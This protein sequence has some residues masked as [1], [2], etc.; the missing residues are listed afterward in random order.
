[1]VLVG[2]GHAHVQV[3]RRFAMERLPGAQ[4]TVVVDIPVA[5]YSGMV[6]GFVAGQYRAEELEID[7]VPLARRAGARVILARAVGID[8]ANHRI[9]VE[10]RP[11]VHYDVASI[12]I[13]STVAGLELPGVR[14]H[15]FPTRPI[16][17]FVRR[18]D[19]LVEQVRRTAGAD[20]GRIVVVGGGAAGVEVA[21]ALDHR[22]KHGEQESPV[23]VSLLE[24][25]PRILPG[26]PDS[27]LRRV[28]RHAEQ[29]RIDI[30]CNQRVV[31][32]DQASVSLEGGRQLPC[33]ALVWV[34][35]AVSQPIFRESGLQTDSRGFVLVR[36]TLQVEGHDE[37]FAVGDCATLIDYPR[38]PK[39]GV[40]AV[41]QGP[42]ISDNLIAFLEGGPLRTYRPQ[43]DFLAL[44]NLADGSALGA[45]WGRAFEGPWVMRLKD[46]IDRRFMRRFQVLEPGGVPTEEF[47]SQ[48]AMSEG[49]MLCGGCA[50][51]L[52]Q[53]SLQRALQRLG[54]APQDESVVLGLS[55]PDDAA[56]Y[57][58]GDGRLVV[59]SVDAFRSLT[60]DP[61]LVGRL[62]AVNAVSDLY[63]QGVSPRYALA[64][65]ALSEAATDEAN[66][67]T[68][69]QVLSGARAA[70][71][72][73]GAALA[74]GHTT[75]A[76]ELMVGFSVAGLASDESELLR[77]DRL[78]AGQ[79]LILSKPL[80][81]GVLFFADMRGLA[82]GP[83]IAA[84]LASMLRPND[85]MVEVARKSGATGA[86]DVSG[87]GLA[88]HLGE[89]VRSSG[90]S[91]VVDIDQLPALAGAVEL[92]GQ[93]LRSTFHPENEKA[94]RGM[95]IR[96][97][98]ARH[99]KLPLLFDPQTSGGLV[100]GVEPEEAEAALASLHARGE[101]SAAIIGRVVGLRDDGALLE[102]RSGSES[103]SADI[104]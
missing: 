59:S 103:S 72:P 14:E 10:G 27:L 88:G 86:T 58:V 84:A 74:G 6:P 98:G 3:L 15:A 37:L 83:W 93:G 40:Y 28:Q 17:R 101:K 47:R 44:L 24:T 42:Y 22:L 25:G 51:K 5:V 18:I 71:D 99:P 19:E 60:D 39:A 12:D 70:L 43:S 45:K 16:G 13:G 96:E 89:M 50:A 97:P 46:W 68:L 73:L 49:E 32:A 79:A 104:G 90:V 100:F 77:I 2:G 85:A 30:Q 7:V 80:G 91:A 33:E 9:E 11:P 53:S 29:R 82:R 94:R 65:V 31:E 1:V 54:P 62:A 4:L 34:T 8:A 63:A 81:T 38:T 35:G 52:G 20:G 55:P 23:A 92:L 57:R 56:A 95:V 64:L 67:E 69:V 48:P 78:R 41:R 66:E 36:S 61:Y 76:A 87:F 102:V 75:T 26:Y 21:F